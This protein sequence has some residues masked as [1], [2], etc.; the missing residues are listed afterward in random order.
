MATRGDT[1]SDAEIVK[2][3]RSELEAVYG[4]VRDSGTGSRSVRMDSGKKRASTKMSL[5]QWTKD[6]RAVVAALVQDGDRVRGLRLITECP[7]ATATWTPRHT[8]ESNLVW[9][10]HL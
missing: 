2:L 7:P 4:A 10:F 9:S 3:A 1:R 8:K 5:R 6:R